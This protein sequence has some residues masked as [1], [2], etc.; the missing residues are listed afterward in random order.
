MP[1]PFHRHELEPADAAAV[2]DVL[3][4]P[5]LTSGRVGA[6]VEEQIAEFLGLPHVLLTNSW[7]NGAIA[8]LLALGIGPGDEVIVPAMTFIATA[9]VVR[10]VGATPVFVDVDPDT[11]MMMADG[12]EAAITART[13]A[14]IP[15]HLYGQMAPMRALAAVAARHG[16][17]LIEDAAHCFE[18]AR[19]GARPG[20]LSDAAIFSFYATKNVT[21]G[22]GGAIATRDTDLAARIRQTRLHGMS[23]GAADRFRGGRYRHWDM[24]RLGTKANLPDL[25]AALLPAQIARVEERRQKREALARRYREALAGFAPDLVLPA[26]VEGAKHAHH[27]FPVHVA[28]HMRDTLLARL[29]ESGIGAT[30]NYRA[31]PQTR[32]WRDFLGEER[33]EHDFPVATRWGEGTFSL[34]LYPSLGEA[35]QDEVI[36][37]L[38]R[39]LQEHLPEGA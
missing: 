3:A 23:A 19:D 18:G 7:T 16:I 29:T 34:P 32:Y 35:E 10:L 8:T 17:R 22:E 9:N 20:A 30:V 4:T 6:A 37:T 39:I 38:A 31:V 5:F 2:A 25:L 13:R 21:C 24:T 1:V 28:P 33:A 27:L 14:A 15:V 11:L 36:E 26:W 12:L